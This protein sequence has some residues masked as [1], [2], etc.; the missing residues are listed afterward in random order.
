[1]LGPQRTMP[2]LGDAVAAL[3]VKGKLAAV[4]AGW[5]EREDEDRELAQHLGG[6]TVSLRLFDRAE[7]VFQKDP[8]VLQAMSEHHSR[9]HGLRDVYRK[10]LGH[11]LEAAREL[12]HST[13]DSRLIEAELDEA[14]S[15]VQ[16]IDSRHVARVAA[17]HQD[18]DARMQ[19]A[20]HPA[21]AKHVAEVA[22]ILDDCDAVCIAGGHVAV[23]YNRLAMFGVLDHVADKPIFAWSAGAMVLSERI[24][25]FH[26]SPPQGAGNPEVLGPGLGMVRGVVPLP[27]AASRLNL[28]DPG[29]VALFAR[30]FAPDICAALEPGSKLLQD[31]EAWSGEATRRLAPTGS[32]EEIAA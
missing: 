22:A 31:G 8:A 19:L 29:R 2:I 13:A 16:H 3:G 20:A 10:H 24:V 30:R 1:M 23:L 26:D 28:E 7:D 14:I 27:H 21:V 12:T 6:R 17:V 4:T 32:L 15:N 11:A 9:L 5:E 18:F 25:L